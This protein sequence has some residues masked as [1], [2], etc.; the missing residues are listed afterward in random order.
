MFHFALL[1]WASVSSPRWSS[2]SLVLLA[3]IS[4]GHNLRRELPAV[5]CAGWEPDE[6]SSS[7][8]LSEEEEEVVG[9]AEARAASQAEAAQRAEDE[10]PVVVQAEADVTADGPPASPRSPSL[11]AAQA[12]AR[13]AVSA[14]LSGPRPPAAGA[15]PLPAPALGSP[16][17]SG[18]TG[19]QQPAQQQQAHGRQLAG[20]ELGAGQLSP[21]QSSSSGWQIVP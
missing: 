18:S 20:N 12:A 11:V 10:E 16:G 4:Y 15:A 3:S 19:K 8:G 13:R 9:E 17:G 6:L 5:P 2:Q 21:R 7:C 14:G 1:C